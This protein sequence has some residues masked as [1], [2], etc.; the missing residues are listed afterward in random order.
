[1]GVVIGETAE[2]GDDCTLYH[3]VT[4][5]GTTW[6]KGKRH[7]T[8]GNNVIIGAGAKVLGPIRVGDGGRIGSNAVVM[9]DVPDG[10]TVVGVPGH[11]VQREP[12]SDDQRRREFARRIGFDAYGATRDMDDPVA[13][14]VNALLDHIHALDGRIE[15]MNAALQRMGVQVESEPVPEL[16]PYGIDPIDNIEKIEENIEDR[17]NEGKEAKE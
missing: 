6:D 12:P 10:A 7:P 2:V 15:A 13:K 5:G 17:T 3:G 8:L 9:K 1:M 11:I 4:L 14:A 16:P